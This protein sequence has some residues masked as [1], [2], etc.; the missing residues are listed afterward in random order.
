MID[1]ES[2]YELPYPEVSKEIAPQSVTPQDP[3][4]F[5]HDH[6][7]IF[8]QNLIK[9]SNE[10]ETKE[11]QEKRQENL[12]AI[13]NY[14]QH[15]EPKLVLMDILIITGAIFQDA[16]RALHQ[17]RQNAIQTPTILLPPSNKI[18]VVL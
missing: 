5:L 7:L 9:G 16:L 10:V 18:E 6:I 15:L 14:V 3:V 17:A 13:I 12:S 8:M 1:L 11:I 4:A 2:P